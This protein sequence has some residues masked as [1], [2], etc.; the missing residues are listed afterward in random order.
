MVSCQLHRGLEVY[1]NVPEIRRKDNPMN[2]DVAQISELGKRWVE[3]ELV[4]DTAANK[5]TDLINGVRTAVTAHAD[6]TGNRT[7]HRRAAATPRTHAEIERSVV[8]HYGV[9]DAPT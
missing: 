9:G 4:A 1:P 8:V 2:N 5:L 7:P 3:A 6:W